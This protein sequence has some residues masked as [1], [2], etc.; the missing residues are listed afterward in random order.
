MQRI[1]WMTPNEIVEW[2]DSLLTGVDEIDRQHRIL[3]NTLNEVA[4]RVSEY[5]GDRRIDQ[6]TRDLLA[7]AAYH[8]ETEEQLMALHG[9]DA[10]EPEEARLH[11]LQHLGF[12]E[13]VIALRAAAEDGKPASL[14]AFLGFLK[15]WLINHI[16]TTDQRLGD[17][18]RS[19]GSRN[20][21]K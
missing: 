20:S 7:F 3:V 16:G 5:S 15:G 10:A 21:G 2:N 4:A 18:I 6:V 8:F 9:Y 11:N 13:R 19:R 17:F 14:A 12:S 1:T